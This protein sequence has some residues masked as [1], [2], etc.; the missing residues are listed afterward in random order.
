MKNN[1]LEKIWTKDFISIAMT[2]LLV[3]IAFYTLLTTLPIYVMQD[4]GGSESDSGLVVTA[5]LLAAIII[6]P[7]SAKILDIIGKKKGLVI[8]VA[9]FTATCFL[10]IWVDQFVP[11]L[12]LRFFHGLSFGVITTATGA[13]AADVIPPARRGAGMGYFAM[14]NNLAVVLGPFIGLTLLQFAS[15]Q[16]L[17]IILSIVMLGSL[18]S[19]LLVQLPAQEKVDQGKSKLQVSDLIELKALPVSLISGLVGLTYASILSFISVYAEALDLASAASYF[20]LVYAIVMLAARPSL[21]RAYDNRGPK[22]V[23]MPCL[24]IFAVGLVFLSFTSSAWMLLIAAGIIG[25]GYGTLLPGFQTMAIQTAHPSRSSHAT[26][27]FFIFYDTGIAAGAFVWGLIVSGLGFQSM[28]LVCAL[29]VLLTMGIFQLY[30]SK[31]TNAKT[32]KQPASYQEVPS[33]K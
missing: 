4:L 1:Q 14:S 6:R 26:A 11:L 22:F 17:F 9:I 32:A 25:L 20:F 23:L 15:F 13:I 21:G 18:V 7:F 31:K 28:F 16:T 29:T 5:M 10:Y 8:T 27:T 2:Q 24:F 30:L 33:S 3:F 19:S 12:A